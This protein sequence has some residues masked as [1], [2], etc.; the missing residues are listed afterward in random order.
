VYDTYSAKGQP[1]DLVGHSMGGLIIRWA[2][3][4]VAVHDS[5]FP[6]SLK[7]SQVVTMSTP[8]DGAIASVGSLAAC[9]N[10]LECD[11]FA[12]NSSFLKSLAAGP[13]PSGTDWSA[14][15]GGPCDLM[16]AASATAVASAHRL[17]WIVPCYT[18]SQIL[19][20]DSQALDA[21]ATFSNPGDATPT[22]TQSAPHSL[23]AVLRALQSSSW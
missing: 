14:L 19:F 20:D 23:A 1:V 10:S 3:S 18:H 13:S 7:V 2:M 12:A 5:A 4:R 22:S 11:Q 9:T 8:Y 6:P 17:S 15:G 21:T 16:T